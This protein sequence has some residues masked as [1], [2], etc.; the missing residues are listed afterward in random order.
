V[1]ARHV[2]AAL[3]YAAGAFLECLPIARR[4]LPLSRTRV[5]FLTQNRAYDGTRARD[6]LGFAPQ[7]DLPDGLA[8]T[9]AWYRQSGLL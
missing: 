8:R 5:T 6:E 7:V 3:A 1:P 4:K 2:P 9:V